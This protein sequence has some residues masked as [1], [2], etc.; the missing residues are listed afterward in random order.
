MG[1]SVDEKDME[2]V[3]SYNDTYD[4][5]IPIFIGDKNITQLY[6]IQNMPAIFFIDHS[7]KIRKH[8]TGYKSKY[9]YDI[10]IKAMVKD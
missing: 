1:I 3:K 5:F 9:V 8:Y 2:I 4:V 6:K 7:G 10:E